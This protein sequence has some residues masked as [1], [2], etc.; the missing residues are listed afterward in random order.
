MAET[1]GRRSERATKKRKLTRFRTACDGTLLQLRCIAFNAAPVPL[2]AGGNGCVHAPAVL[3][4]TQKP[5]ALLTFLDD[6]PFLEYQRGW[7]VFFSLLLLLC[8]LYSEAIRPHT[9]QG[10]GERKRTGEIGEMK[11]GRSLWLARFQEKCTAPAQ[12]PPQWRPIP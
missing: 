4:P 9:G 1:E 12:T 7:R 8:S 2:F 10:S 6:E 5:H 3:P 11:I